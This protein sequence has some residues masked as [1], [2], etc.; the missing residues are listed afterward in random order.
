MLPIDLNM[1]RSVATFLALLFVVGVL[2]VPA[3]HMAHCAACHDAHDGSHC[4]ICQIANTPVVATAPQIE[5][6][7]QTLVFVRIYLPQSLTPSAPM[8]RTAQARGPPVA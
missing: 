3:L 2:L 5:L 7:A 6:V 4:P 8:S 1:K